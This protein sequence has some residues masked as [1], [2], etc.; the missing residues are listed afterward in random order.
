MLVG[1]WAEGD[2][3]ISLVR[4]W[5]NTSAA[6]DGDIYYTIIA[7]SFVHLVMY[8][9]YLQ[10]TLLINVWWKKYLTQLQMVQFVTMNAQ[11]CARVARPRGPPPPRLLLTPLVC[12][13]RQAVYILYNGC[14]FPRNVTAV[15]LVYIISLLLLFLRFYFRMT[16]KLAR[17]RKA[18]AAQTGAKKK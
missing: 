10:Q 11:V 16:A 2:L 1:L 6:Y 7:N 3:S 17:D 9:Y 8:Y 12:A 18:A 13:R 5:L 15:Y 14:P 4:Y